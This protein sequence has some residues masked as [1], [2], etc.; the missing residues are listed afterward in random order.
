MIHLAGASKE[1][2]VYT[3]TENLTDFVLVLTRK[4][5]RE[6]EEITVPLIID[7]YGNSFYK[8][9]A[10]TLPTLETIEYD[11][12]ITASG[13]TIDKGILRHGTI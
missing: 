4:K 8:L 2:Y 6:L 10:P 1:L 13:K 9:E 12:E 7:F 3:G 5:G 11:Y